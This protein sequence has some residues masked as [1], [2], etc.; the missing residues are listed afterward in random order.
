MDN[1]I[2]IIDN[3]DNNQHKFEQLI[4]HIVGNNPIAALIQ[5]PPRIDIPQL[6]GGMN[7]LGLNYQAI[8]SDATDISN[9]NKYSTLTLVNHDLAEVVNI[10]L[11]K[12]QPSAVS[13]L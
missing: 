11:Q 3:A 13:V 12:E 2:I 6:K 9:S 10:L 4:R 7:S 1:P 8:A 5:D